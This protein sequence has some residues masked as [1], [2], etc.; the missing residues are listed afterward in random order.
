[1]YDQWIGF[2]GKILTGN[3][4]FSKKKYGALYDVMIQEMRG[5]H[6]FD[7]QT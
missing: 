2:A 4:R 5:S 1:M 7:T 3:H 6:R